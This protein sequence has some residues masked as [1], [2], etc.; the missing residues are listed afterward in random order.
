M[1][2][3]FLSG[4]TSILEGAPSIFE[5]LQINKTVIAHSITH[6][7]DYITCYA[8]GKWNIT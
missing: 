4:Q 3:I 6:R 1:Y 2:T 5:A 8:I 7:H